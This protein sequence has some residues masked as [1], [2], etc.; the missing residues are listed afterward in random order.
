MKIYFVCDGADDWWV[1]HGVLENGFYFG[2]HACSHPCFAPSDLYFQRPNRISALKEL[3]GI[4]PDSVIPETIVIK[5]K[6]DI[7]VWW[8]AIEE[9][10]T[11]FSAEYKKYKELVGGTKSSVVVEMS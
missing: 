7:P 5:S 8:G 10:H 3:F 6:D 1:C 2:Q 4:T 11:K 9:G